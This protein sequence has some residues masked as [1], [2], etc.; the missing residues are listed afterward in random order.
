MFSPD[1]IS[2]DN[3]LLHIEYD[4][5]QPLFFSVVRTLRRM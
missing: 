2:F 5:E 3:L 1:T 4:G